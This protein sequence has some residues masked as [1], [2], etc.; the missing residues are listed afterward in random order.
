M[1]FYSRM[2]AF[3]KVLLPL[4]ALAILSTLFLLSR[5][6]DPTANIPFSEQD[7]TER[8]RGQQVTK[9]FFS[10]T[11]AKGDD[12]IVH[13]S[14]AHPGGPGKPAEAEDVTARMVTADGIRLDLQADMLTVDFVHDAAT[15]IGDVKLRS[16]SGIQVTTDRLEAE[17]ERVAG[18]TPGEVIA[19]GPMGHLKAG[20]FTWFSRAGSS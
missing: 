12:I 20:R 9:P 16:S 15:F 13:A 18:S 2:V 4:A 10:G 14:V 8:I 3:L 5:S 7:V 1:D 17:T 11:T 6:I 19:T